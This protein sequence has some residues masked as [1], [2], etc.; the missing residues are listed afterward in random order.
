VATNE[1]VSL[2]YHLA[3]QCKTVRD[4]EGH[5]YSEVSC[6]QYAT[7]S[8]TNQPI[9]NLYLLSELADY[10]IKQ[11]AQN[12][13][14][15]IP[16]YPDKINMPKDIFSPLPTAA[17][18]KEVRSTVYLTDEKIGWIG[19]MGKAMKSPQAKVNTTYFCERLLI[20]VTDQ[21]EESSSGVKVEVSAEYSPTARILMSVKEASQETKEEYE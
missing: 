9:Q 4:K 7:P 5:T 14:W 15:T 16:S 18:A 20:S 2:L 21:E 11:R 13:G 6:A 8:P 17:A 3:Q 10:A 1:N 12:N 19:E